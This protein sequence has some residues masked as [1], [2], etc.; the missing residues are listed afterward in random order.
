MEGFV[1]SMIRFRIWGDLGYI[2]GNELE[3]ESV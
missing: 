3:W 1:R 2:V